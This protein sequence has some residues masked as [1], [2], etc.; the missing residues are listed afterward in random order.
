MFDATDGI[1]TMVSWSSISLPAP[2][3][4]TPHILVKC[5]RG[6]VFCRRVEMDR[7][8]GSPYCLDLTAGSRMSSVSGVRDRGSQKA[9][10]CVFQRSDVK[11]A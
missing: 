10:S 8:S 2:L 4:S 7:P 3:V 6:D 9:D 1:E 11:V 5:T